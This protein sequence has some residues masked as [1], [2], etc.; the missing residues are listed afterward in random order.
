MKQK[1]KNRGCTFLFSFMPGAAE[2]Y[3]G[4]MKQGLSLMGLF[5]LVV[6]LQLSYGRTSLLI[7][8]AVLIWFYSFFHARN[9]D[10]CEEE[11]FEKLEDEFIWS[12]VAEENDIRIS[13]PVVRKVLSWALLLG[14]VA[15][16]WDEVS[17]LI[18]R[19]IPNGLWEKIYYLVDA[20]PDIAI[21]TFI[22]IVGIRMIK[23][24][25]KE[26]DIKNEK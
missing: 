18:Y 8:G 19:W 7:F 22:I 12:A 17:L 2:M 14:G 9:L 26:L 1:K 13:N 11:E 10:A 4:F 23:G 24:K 21:A 3:M 16:L 6:S 5:L 25:K 15:L 20:V